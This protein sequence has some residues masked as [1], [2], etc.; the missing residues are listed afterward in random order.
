MCIVKEHV[1]HFDARN[2][3]YGYMLVYS[4]NPGCKCPAYWGEIVLREKANSTRFCYTV[5]ELDAQNK[6]YRLTLFTDRNLLCCFSHS[7]INF[8]DGDSRTIRIHT[9]EENLSY[10]PDEL[11]N[12]MHFMV[13]RCLLHLSACYASQPNIDPRIILEQKRGFYFHNT[14]MEDFERETRIP[15]GTLISALKLVLE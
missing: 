5:D 6:R 12:M 15:L 7:L 11:F 9:I 14:F 1:E 2:F 13:Y 8:I 4:S 10:V 3:P